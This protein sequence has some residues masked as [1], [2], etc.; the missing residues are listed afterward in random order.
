MLAGLG[1]NLQLKLLGLLFRWR[2]ISIATFTVIKVAS[3]AGNLSSGQL[4]IQKLLHL[5][6]AV[7]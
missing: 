6:R 1:N 3:Y 4:F 2:R 5:C 7:A